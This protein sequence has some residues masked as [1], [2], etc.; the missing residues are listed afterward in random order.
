MTHPAG[1]LAATRWR[2]GG[3]GLPEEDDPGLAGLVLTAHHLRKPHETQLHRRRA[4]DQ[5]TAAF[6]YA[7]RAAGNGRG[8]RPPPLVDSGGG[9]GLLQQ[10]TGGG[11]SK[12]GSSSHQEHEEIMKRMEM[13]PHVIRNK[14]TCRLSAESFLF[15]FKLKSN[16]GRKRESFHFISE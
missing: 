13:F 3:A 8:P 11:V 7:Q 1:G 10:D 15:K 9:R 14:K 16:D 5:Q 6:N 2:P 4:A 12:H